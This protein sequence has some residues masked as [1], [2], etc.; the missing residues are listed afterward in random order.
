M[1]RTRAGRTVGAAKSG[2]G[3]GLKNNHNYVR[4]FDPNDNENNAFESTLIIGGRYGLSSK[5]TRPSQIIAVFRNLKEKR[6]KD[7]FTIGIVDDVT[8][9]SLP[10][11]EIV[12]TVPAG[13]VSCKIYG[14]GS[15]GTVGANKAAAKI[16]GDNTEL[17]VQAY[18]SYDSKKSG[19]TTVSHL[20]SEAP[21][22]SP[23]QVYNADYIPVTTI[24]SLQ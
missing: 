8:N 6:P 16:I 17:R 14:L 9:T 2:R 19:G 7:G 3:Q 20:R 23:Y 11:E 4:T 15:D 13:T 22:R 21:H 10:E 24:V 1:D 5:D 18:F 12:D